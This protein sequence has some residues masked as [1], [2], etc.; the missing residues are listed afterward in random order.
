MSSDSQDFKV[1]CHPLTTNT[2]RIHD[3]RARE[4]AFLNSRV[5]A[6]EVRLLFVVVCRWD[7]GLDDPVSPAT[8]A[9]GPFCLVVDHLHL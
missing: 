5:P 3:L 1:E 2:T 8:T 9:G 6:V 4:L 7:C